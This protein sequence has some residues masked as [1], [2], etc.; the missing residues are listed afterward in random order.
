M[1][2]TKLINKAKKK[3]KVVEKIDISW[4][5]HVKNL[6]ENIFVVPF[7]GNYSALIEDNFVLVEGYCGLLFIDKVY[8]NHKTY[9]L[10]TPIKQDPF[11]I[12]GVYNLKGRFESFVARPEIGFH[13]MGMGNRGHNICTGELQYKNPRSLKTLK[14]ITLQ[15]IGSLRLINMESLGTVLL[16]DSYASL[17]TIFLA[18]DGKTGEKLLAEGLIE[19]IF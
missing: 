3:S 19:E 6:K 10:K 1:I 18:K 16:P 9:L 12:Y 11:K 13:Y 8:Y 4:R 14:E 15:I 5:Q 17:K 2:D 7:K